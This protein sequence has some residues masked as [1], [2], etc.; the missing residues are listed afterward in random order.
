M[1]ENVE[2]PVSELLRGMRTDIS[3]TKDDIGTIKAELLIMRQHVAGIVGSQTL[4]NAKVVG[5]EVGIERIER[6]LE[7]ID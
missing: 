3:L 4:E 6:R 1:S 7:L 5:L 2:N